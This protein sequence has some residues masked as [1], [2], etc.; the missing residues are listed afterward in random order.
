VGYH[1]VLSSTGELLD[2]R[3]DPSGIASLDRAA[4]QAVMTAAPFPQ[5]PDMNATTFRL[6]GTIIYRLEN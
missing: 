2:H 1:L 4:E 5:P 6:S 3:I